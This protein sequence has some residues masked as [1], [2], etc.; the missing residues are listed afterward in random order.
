MRTPNINSKKTGARA[1]KDSIARAHAKAPYGE[2]CIITGTVNPD[3][4]LE[5][6]AV[7]SRSTEPL[8]ASQTRLR[9]CSHSDDAQLDRLEYAWGY[10]YRQLD[11]D[12]SDSLVMSA[13]AFSTSCLRRG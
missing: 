5:D 2:R 3:P 13:Y 1:T 6:C 8:G 12:T 11:G 4:G 7:V 9:A 10:A